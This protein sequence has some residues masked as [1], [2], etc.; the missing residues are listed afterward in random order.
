VGLRDPLW[1]TLWHMTRTLELSDDERKRRSEAMSELNRSGRRGRRRAKTDD[2]RIRESLMQVVRTGTPRQRLDAT[3]ELAALDERSPAP[4]RPDFEDM[5]PSEL[6]EHLEALVMRMVEH[7]AST[8][9][10][11]AFRAECAKRGYADLFDRAVARN[12]A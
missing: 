1:G 10:L 11:A 9:L 4:R 3:R 8:R 12:T 5:T 7:W 6:D 2:E